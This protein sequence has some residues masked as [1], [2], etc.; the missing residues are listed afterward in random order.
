VP[1]LETIKKEHKY[2]NWIEE[3]EKEFRVLKEN[4][5]KQPILVLPYFNKK[6]QVR[7][8]ASGLGH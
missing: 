3:A 4:I 5:T 2:F 1:I 6:I 7:C 8:D